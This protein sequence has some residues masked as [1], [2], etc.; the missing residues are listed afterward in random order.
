VTMVTI[1]E[2]GATRGWPW[3]GFAR[4]AIWAKRCWLVDPVGPPNVESYQVQASCPAGE[5]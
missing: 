5:G 4:P 2:A 1:R 3:S